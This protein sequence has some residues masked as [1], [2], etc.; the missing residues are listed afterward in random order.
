MKHHW[1]IWFP[2][3]MLILLCIFFFYISF[4]VFSWQGS[5]LHKIKEFIIHNISTVIL[6]II[7]WLSRKYPSWC[8]LLL[9]LLGYTFTLQYHTYRHHFNFVTSKQV[10]NFLIRSVWPILTGVFFMYAGTLR[11][12][13]FNSEG[14]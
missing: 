13:S 9:I 6:L 1:F 14:S 3:I 5:S 8:G 2:R 4:H 12:K 7:L 11:P 10:L